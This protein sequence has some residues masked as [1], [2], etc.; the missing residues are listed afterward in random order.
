MK[1]SLLLFVLVASLFSQAQNII[2]GPYIQQINT[3]SV[4]IKWKT[5]QNTSSKVSFGVDSTNLNLSELSPVTTQDHELTITGLNPDTKYYYEVGNQFGPLASHSFQ[6]TYF[7][8]APSSPDGSVTRF[9]VLGDAGTANTNQ[10]AV[11]DAYYGYIGNQ[12]TD[13]ILMLGDNAYD[14]GTDA[15]YQAAVFDMYTEKL[16]SASLWSCV[17]NHEVGFFEGGASNSSTQSGPYYDAFTFPTNAEVGGVASGTESYYSFDY[18]NIHFIVLNSAD[19][20]LGV[21]EV[22]YNW[23]QSDLS[24]TTKDWIVMI[25]HHPPYTKGSHDSDNPFPWIDGQL[26]DM[27]ENYLPLLEQYGVDLVM[28]GHSHSYE[29]SFLLRGH[30]DDSGTFNISTHAVDSGSGDP[31]TSCAYQKT[32]SGATA[33]HG[34]V[35]VTA[36]SSGKT[37]GGDLDHP[38]MYTS[39]NEL[40]S[41]VVEIRGKRMDVVFIKETGQVIDRYA[42]VKDDYITIECPEDTTIYVAAP[43]TDAVH[44]YAAPTP[45]G[46]CAGGT[47]VAQTDATG[48]SSGSNFPIGTTSLEYTA[49]YGANQATCTFDITVVSNVS[50]EEFI[51]D[52]LVVYPTP[53]SGVLN[54]KGLELGK[55]YNFRIY[56]MTGKMVYLNEAVFTETFHLDL[57]LLE[58]GTYLVKIIDPDFR[59]VETKI[60]IQK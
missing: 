46:L 20:D 8:T 19:E 51:Q 44:S 55:S 26:V 53:T 57:S 48:L 21:G 38:A 49:S 10:E 1:N 60:Q 2:R 9:W 25:W 22:M 41:C 29:R 40:G 6:S 3:N 7:Q 28:C 17:G 11:R 39:L 13:G 16:R 18:D 30:H 34:T 45:Y 42:I 24:Q 27:R 15:E 58:N 50:L 32:T 56:D 59:S 47:T 52:Q 33:G 14:S 31:I 4:I 43:A 23:A 54:I 37:S 5:D 12:H 35:Y 36:G